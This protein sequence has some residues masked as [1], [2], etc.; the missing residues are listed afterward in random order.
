MWIYLIVFI[1]AAL[2]GW[3]FGKN[4]HVKHLSQVL[5]QVPWFP[6]EKVGEVVYLVKSYNKIQ[7]ETKKATIAAY[8][9]SMVQSQLEE[10]RRE[11]D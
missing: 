4:A 9:K 2:F 3:L 8:K 11:E 6:N 5:Y 10:M 7:R 1:A